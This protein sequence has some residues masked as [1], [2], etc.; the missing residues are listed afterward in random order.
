MQG[1]IHSKPKSMN[2]GNHFVKSVLLRGS[3]PETYSVDSFLRM[4]NVFIK[5]FIFFFGRNPHVIPVNKIPKS[6][7]ICPQKAMLNAYEVMI[8]QV[9]W[10]A[11][12][13]MWTMDF[14][15]TKM[16]RYG[17]RYSDISLLLGSVLIQGFLAIPL[18]YQLL[19]NHTK[20]NFHIGF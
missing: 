3:H 8:C 2:I 20:P 9:Q 14:R 15:A 6:S 16:L 7:P 1:S 17:M 5:H 18:L 11:V 13:G 10:Q 19:Q 12:L 4:M